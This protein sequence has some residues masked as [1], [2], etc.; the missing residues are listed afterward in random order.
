MRSR[1]RRSGQIDQSTVLNMLS[2]VVF[3]A[4]ARGVRPSSSES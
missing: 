4:D 1:Q 2:R 3:S